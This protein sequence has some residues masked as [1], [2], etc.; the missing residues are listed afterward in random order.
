MALNIINSLNVQ[1]QVNVNDFT[2]IRP[3]H[4]MPCPCLTPSHHHFH[5][6]FSILSAK[7][8]TCFSIFSYLFPVPITLITKNIN[9]HQRIKK[10]FKC[11]HVRYVVNPYQHHEAYHPIW[12]LDS[13]SINFVN[14]IKRKYSQINV[15]IKIVRKKNWCPSTVHRVN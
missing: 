10:M 11:Q 6:I 15:R 3:C 1:K 8:L 5:W 9:A 14:R 13:I 12:L 4:A 2:S 7:N